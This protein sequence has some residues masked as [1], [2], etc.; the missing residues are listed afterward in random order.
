M[1]KK[2][3]E[4]TPFDMTELRN[5][6]TENQTASQSSIQQLGETLASRLDALTTAITALVD[7]Q[8]QHRTHAPPPVQQHQPFPQPHALARHQQQQ[9]R[10]QQQH[11]FYEDEDDAHQRLFYEDLR[12]HDNRDDRWGRGFRVDIPEFHGGLVMN[13]L[14]G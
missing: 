6:L 2:T 12:R 4:G 3:T 10:N 5:L 9:Q 14:I 7:Q 13:F 11:P 1:A 8:S